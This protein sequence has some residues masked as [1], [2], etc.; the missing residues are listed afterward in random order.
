MGVYRIKYQ[1]ELELINAFT[2]GLCSLIFCCNISTVG[3][4][5]IFNHKLLMV[6]PLTSMYL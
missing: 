6:L 3:C 4:P 5:L 1:V 2:Y